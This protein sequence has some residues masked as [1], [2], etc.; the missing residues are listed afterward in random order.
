[1]HKRTYQ[2]LT[3]LVTVALVLSACGGAA[4]P[5][6]APTTPDKISLQLKWATQAQFAGYYAALDQGFYKNENLD[7]TILE[8]GPN[9]A[10]E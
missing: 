9:I 3:G 2:V 10:P 8:G 6:A 5:T 4:A 1:M 7:V